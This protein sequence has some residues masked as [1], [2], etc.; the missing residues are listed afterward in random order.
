MGNTFSHK[1]GGN[2]TPLHTAAAP[3]LMRIVLELMRQ[4][5]DITHGADKATLAGIFD[6]PLHQAAYSGHLSTLR[7]LLEHGCP[8]DKL[9]TTGFTVLHAA[10]AGGN[11]DVIKELIDI[12]CDVNATD[13]DNWTPLHNA[14]AY[15]KTKAALELIRH[16]A[17]KSIV[18]GRFGP[19]LHWAAIKGHLTLLKVLLE[20]GCPLDTLSTTGRTI[21]HHA[22]EGG[23]VDIIKELIDRGCDVNATDEDNLT[24]LHSAAIKGKTEAVLELIRHGA[25]KAI[26]AGRFGTPLHQAAVSGHLTTLR[27]LLEHGCP[28]DTHSSTGR[29]V[30]HHAAEGGN[31]D[32]IKELIDRGG[33]VNAADEDNLTPLNFAATKGKTEAALELI[34]HGAEKA[35]VAGRF[36]TPLHQAA[37][38]GHL[39]TLRA[40]LEYE[41]PL[42]TVNTTSCTV[43]HAAAAGGN[44]D[45]IKELIDRGGDV[46]AADKD[47]LTPLH[48]AAAAGKTG[49]AL[50]LMR[51]GADKA[52]V[53]GIF[54]TPLHQAAVKGHL[55]T[56][57]ALLDHGCPLDTLS[58]KG[59]T[60]LH[61]AAVGG[62]VDII[63][64]LIDRGCD[65]NATDED[66]LT[67]LHSAAIKGKTE[68][69]MELIRHGA[70][71]AIVAG[72]FG[73]PLHQ[74]AI[75]GHLMTLR[76]LLEHGCPLDTLST[77][78]RT[79]LHAAAEGGNV[80]VIKELIDRGCD[81]NAIA[82]NNWTP[83]HCAA[84]AGKTE[85]ALEL[86][87]HGADK[88]IIA[89]RAGTPLHQAA[90]RG[91]FTTLRALLE[92]GC[93]LDTLSTKG[94]TVLHHAAE[95]GN[96]D[97][98][99]ELIDRGCDVNA[100]ADNNWTPLHSAAAAGKTEAALELI[101]HGAGKAMLANNIGTPLH[102]AV[103]HNHVSTVEALLKCECSIDAVG[104]VTYIIRTQ[105]DNSIIA[106]KD[107]RNWTPLHSAAYI[108]ATEAGLEL[109]QHGA[110]LHITAG[111]YGTPFEQACLI[112]R[113]ALIKSM[114]TKDC[115][116]IHVLNSINGTPLHAAAQG[117]NPEVIKLLLSHNV[118]INAV[119]VYGLSPLHYAAAIGG[120]EAYCILVEN[121]ADVH[122]E[123]PGH[124]TP[125]H[126]ACIAGNEKITTHFP[127]ESPQSIKE[128]LCIR[129]IGV[130]TTEFSISRILSQYADSTHFDHAINLLRTNVYSVNLHNLIF[131]GA[132]LGSGKILDEIECI[133]KDDHTA[134]RSFLSTWSTLTVEHVKWI[135]QLSD[136]DPI[137]T[138]ALT[139]G[140]ILS[141][142][143]LS[144]I[145][146]K[147]YFERSHLILYWAPHHYCD[148]VSELSSNPVLCQHYCG[149]QS[150]NWSIHPIHLADHLHLP[151]IAGVLHKAG[152]GGVYLPL[153]SSHTL[154][155][156]L[157]VMEI[158]FQQMYS[159][160]V[161]PN[162][163][164]KAWLK[165]KLSYLCTNDEDNEKALFEQKPQ[166]NQLIK[167]IIQQTKHSYTDDDLENVHYSLDMTDPINLDKLCTLKQ[168]L[169][170]W[171]ENG[172]RPTWTQLLDVLDEHETAKTMRTIR[173]S[174]SDNLYGTVLRSTISLTE[175]IMPP[176]SYILPNNQLK[177]PTQHSLTIDPSTFRT[178]YTVTLHS[179]PADKE[180]IDTVLPVVYTKWYNFGLYLGVKPHVLDGVRK[181]ISVQLVECCA[182]V[183]RHWTN[184]IH[185]SG[186][187]R[188][189]WNNV[190]I[191]AIK[192][193]GS[194]QVCGILTKFNFKESDLSYDD[195]PK[196]GLSSNES[197]PELVHVVEHVIPHIEGDWKCV[198]I[199]LGVPISLVRSL[200]QDFHNNFDS[201]REAFNQLLSGRGVVGVHTPIT[202][203]SIF[204]AITENVGPH[205]TDKIKKSLNNQ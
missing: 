1:R 193:V 148:F 108:G 68:A 54:G 97:V 80:D 128:D 127:L 103:L 19:P 86:I 197:I 139:P 161:V 57:K 203:Q 119:D 84:A 141:P 125:L 88:G 111:L 201:C 195:F 90:G 180:L 20:H 26:V 158:M 173:K 71:K 150:S 177:V 145:S 53:A 132:L 178:Q 181:S 27:A 118:P 124:G 194:Y 33:D 151:D 43:L 116:V 21:L 179:V 45:V 78:G 30:L 87:R 64:Q 115:S 104:S 35:I 22:A 4:T 182:E 183:V 89:G 76:A 107:V 94:C 83:L 140:K 9:S 167:Y 170:Y 23:N 60:V 146:R 61:H 144:M 2:W 162:S 202:W 93:P 163:K 72:R 137:V 189:S 101:G 100:I 114:L 11:V 191:A 48:N 36:G 109:I 58:T 95:G 200:L 130:T 39:T 174:L 186:Q 41:C 82:D 147:L 62:N 16:G 152:L 123:A 106:V 75:G 157:P 13:K 196:P 134:R 142:F 32:V 190:V 65:V 96:V 156:T 172:T 37:G 66:N 155:P 188:R 73:T 135:F 131:L 205:V 77:A 113:M 34:R 15:G 29:T 44:V 122:Y 168:L 81:F 18:A 204:D 164:I 51:H 38:G 105:E 198:V 175:T 49:A 110:N 99:K 12:G 40:L 56:L 6:M 91:D 136:T 52:I 50:E 74:A 184:Y 166:K 42:D 129:S 46:N 133:L 160:G 120:W 149:S 112:G 165:Q 171:L 63:K 169:F 31:V 187:K 199:S 92:H 176:A 117:N 98:I 79:V 121:G 185:N 67:P 10:A 24:P 159:S 5:M 28:L 59:R 70:D 55:T 192:T 7:A 8:L 126:L 47:N 154:V 143:H 17:D 3:R 69:V 85:A 25:D 14:V 102:L 138:T 153:E